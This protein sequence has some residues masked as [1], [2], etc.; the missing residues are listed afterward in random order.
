M[1]CRLVVFVLAFNVGCSTSGPPEDESSLV[2]STDADAGGDGAERGSLSLGTGTHETSQPVDRS[3][4]IWGSCAPRTWTTGAAKVLQKAGS[5]WRSVPPAYGAGAPVESALLP[6]GTVLI[7]GGQAIYDPVKDVIDLLP[8]RDGIDFLEGSSTVS[9]GD[10]HSVLVTAGLRA[11][12]FDVT[13]RTFRNVG[14]M[15]Y[16][17][18]EHASYL[19]PDGDV[20]VLTGEHDVPRSELFD[21]KTDTWTTIPLPDEW[22][23]HWDDPMRAPISVQLDGGDVL[24]LRNATLRFSASSHT[25]RAVSWTEPKVWHTPAVRLPDGRVLSQVYTAGPT[26]FETFD[27][28]TETWSP[29]YPMPED[30]AADRHYGDSAV[31]LPCRKVMFYDTGS[32]SVPAREP[33]LLDV[34]TGKW[35]VVRGATPYSVIAGSKLLLLRDGSVLLTWGSMKGFGT[36]APLLFRD[37]SK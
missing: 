17:H 23:A 21:P 24:V 6:D 1:R 9:L 3:T 31:L 25:W 27:P 26:A 20:L 28:V 13:T 37:E 18:G 15:H 19:L 35:T 16:P 33:Y 22:Y 30:L 2:P 12:I 10:G 34:D 14:P 7:G 29:A 5:L 11:E 36:W 4:E 32:G 8:M